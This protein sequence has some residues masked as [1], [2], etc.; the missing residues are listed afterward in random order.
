MSKLVAKCS[1]SI[2]LLKAYRYNIIK[3]TL[4]SMTIRETN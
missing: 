1:L 4:D 3:Y 2:A